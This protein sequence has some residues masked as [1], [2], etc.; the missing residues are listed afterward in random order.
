MP[1]QE[2]RQFGVWPET[3]RAFKSLSFYCDKPLAHL[4]NEAVQ[5]LQAKYAAEQQQATPLRRA[6]DRTPTPPTAA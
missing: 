2:F 3:H 4:A 1:K 5:L 6:T